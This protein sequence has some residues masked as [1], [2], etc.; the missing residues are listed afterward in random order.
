LNLFYLDRDLDRCAE[1]HIDKHVGKLQLEAAQLLCTT[2][3]V[4]RYVGFCPRKLTKEELGVIKD[5][6]SHEP[7]IDDRVFTRYLPSHINHPCSIWVRSS[8]EN[9]HWTI[10][11]I[12]ALD[13]ESQWR[14]NKPHS[15]C[16]VALTLPEPQRLPD[17]GW[18]T[19]AMAMPDNYKSTDPVQSYREY[20]RGDKSSI[21]SWKRRGP[22]EWWN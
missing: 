18:L 6:V 7:A 16:R 4:D 20:Y 12:T 3:W 13:A 22:P 9:Y 17:V 14:G 2:L 15:S 11:Y 21:A 1:Y 10:N 5:A 19:P 8:L